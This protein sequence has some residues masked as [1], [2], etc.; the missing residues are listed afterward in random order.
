[1]RTGEVRDSRPCALRGRSRDRKK[2]KELRA[3]GGFP[4]FAEPRSGRRDKRLSRQAELGRFAIRAHA[5][6]EEGAGIER[7]PKS[8]ERLEASR[9]SRS[10]AAAAVTS[11]CRD[12]RNWGGSRFAP[13]R[14]P[15]KEQG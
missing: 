8:F 2:P 10:R 15:R 6:S 1:M 4:C 3:L 13:M 5:L 9:A 7:N 12:K 11:G 14:S